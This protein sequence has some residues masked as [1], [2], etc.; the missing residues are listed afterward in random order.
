MD[1]IETL[2]I[3]WALLLKEYAPSGSTGHGKAGQIVCCLHPL[4][5]TI[6]PNG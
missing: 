6:Y 3:S 2:L 5:W 1:L 4:I